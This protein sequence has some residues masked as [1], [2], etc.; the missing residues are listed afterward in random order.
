MG[1]WESSFLFS[2]R[3][4][5]ESLSGCQAS[6]RGVCIVHY[7]VGQFQPAFV[8]LYCAHVASFCPCNGSLPLKFITD[9][10]DNCCPV[11]RHYGDFVL[12]FLYGC[13]ENRV[14]MVKIDLFTAALSFLLMRWYP[15]TKG[16]RDETPTEPVLH[17]R[18]QNDR[19]A[20]DSE[21]K[22]MVRS[23]RVF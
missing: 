21:T 10:R 5:K 2:I 3:K 18:R 15:Q 17:R 11:V 7:R 14:L 12:A 1:R 13:T 22:V 23:S 9:S 16:R 20:M 6:G 8:G 4:D 19:T